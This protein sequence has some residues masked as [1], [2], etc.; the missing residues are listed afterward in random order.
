M[1][2][3]TEALQKGRA[4]KNRFVMKAKY[5]DLIFYIGFM[6]YPVAQFLVF[7][8]GVNINSVLLSFQRIDLYTDTTVFTFDV[9]KNAL[10]EFFTDY[11]MLSMMRVSVVTYLLTL[12]I[13][14]PL[15]LLF[16]FYIYK[17]FPLSGAFRV[18]LFLPSIISAIVMATIYNGFVSRAIPAIVGK[19]TGTWPKGLLDN[20][21][22]RYG[23]LLFYSI[24]MGFGTNVLLYSNG[25]SGISPDI[26][27]SA[28]LD[29]CVGIREFWHI[30]LPMVFSTLSTFLVTGLAGIFTGQFNLYSF[31]GPAAPTSVRTYG[32]QMYTM[33]AGASRTAYPRISALGLIMTV[34]IVPLTLLLRK[35][36]EKFGPKED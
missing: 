9:M 13:G 18:I 22:T 26:V 2:D 32:Y 1:N 30:S 28:H 10:K 6:I 14:T 16:S 33:A 7:Y 34:I 17:K 25:M 12:V 3:K 20:P 31:Y 27:D 11:T 5:K 29:G 19:I 8:V 4:H 24:W 23:T 35:A 21:A 36:L 15:A